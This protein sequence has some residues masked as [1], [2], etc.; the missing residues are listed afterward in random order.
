MKGKEDL[1]IWVVAAFKTSRFPWAPTHRFSLYLVGSHTIKFHV[2]RISF[3]RE[4]FLLHFFTF[5]SGNNKMDHRFCDSSSLT[6]VETMPSPPIR[7][8]KLS[9][10]RSSQPCL[11]SNSSDEE[12]L[13]MD[14]NSDDFKCDSGF[15]E[16]PKSELQRRQKFIITAGEDLSSLGKKTYSNL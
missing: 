4:N 2:R 15:I 1:F 8:R 6:S 11:N 7:N 13:I 9:R 5:C 3:H 12:E 16:H 14:Q 10:R